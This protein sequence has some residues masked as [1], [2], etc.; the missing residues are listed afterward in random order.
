MAVEDRLRAILARSAGESSDYDLN[1][2]IRLPEGR[3]L[4]PAAVLVPVW[5]RPEGPRMILTKR[6]S[7]LQ[8]HPGQVAFPGGKIDAGDGSPE[9]AALREAA[10]EIGLSAGLVTILGRLPAH[11]TVTGFTVTP[12]L[13]VVRGGFVPV[14][15]AGEVDEV[16]S[17]PLDLVLTAGN[18]AVERRLWRG[19]WRRYYAVPWGPHYIWGATARI[20]RGMA[21]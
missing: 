14:P 21:D 12:V 13:A 2:D 5:L 7:H 4:R 16:F 9:A 10:E 1:P 18:Y 8:H 15:E 6:S 19:Q 3:V 11:E 20:L 17:V